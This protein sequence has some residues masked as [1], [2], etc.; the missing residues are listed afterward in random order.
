VDALGQTVGAAQGRAGKPLPEVDGLL[1]IGHD[2]GDLLA[3]VVV[4]L[5]GD[6]RALVLLRQDQAAAQI[7]NL[8]VARA[9]LGL[10]GDQPLFRAATPRP[11]DEQRSDERRLR[12]EQGDG[13]GDVAPIAIPDRRLLEEDLGSRRHTR[14]ADPPAPELPPV[15]L[16]GVQIN[17]RIRDGVRVLAAQHAQRHRADGVDLRRLA[18]KAAANNAMVHRGV[19]PAVGRGAGDAG[20]SI[21]IGERLE[22]LALPVPIHDQVV[23]DRAFGQRGET[24]LKRLARKAGQIGEVEARLI[25]GELRAGHAFVDGAR[26]F[27]AA[28]HEHMPEIR[29]QLGGERERGGKVQFANHRR[30]IRQ[31]PRTA[32]SEKTTTGTP[33]N[34]SSRVFFEELA[35]VVVHRDEQVEG[36]PAVLNRRKSAKAVT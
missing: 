22:V 28:D 35:G 31:P 12:H 6:P 2:E 11:L 34:R 26:R 1:Q 7:R 13:A 36:V 25:T 9:Q 30:R 32:R 16:R 23:D 24:R 8:L 27:G 14:L 5:P 4:Q 19:D 15:D 18:A 20:D 21:Q 29:L 10:A 33:G 17:G 3:D